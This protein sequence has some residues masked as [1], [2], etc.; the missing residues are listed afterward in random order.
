MDLE[1]PDE[2]RSSV[3]IYLAAS[4]QKLIISNGSEACLVDISRLGKTR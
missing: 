1:I 2:L 4:E 3:Q